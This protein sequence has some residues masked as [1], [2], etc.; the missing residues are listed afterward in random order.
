LENR[1]SFVQKLLYAQGSL[2]QNVANLVVVTWVIYFYTG[3]GG[4]TALIPIALVGLIMGVGRVIDVITDPLVGYWSDKSTYKGGRRRPFI[5]W[6]GPLLALTFYLLWLPPVSE[7]SWWNVLWAFLFINAFFLMLTITIVPFRSVL[8]DIAPNSRERISVSAWQAVFG[9]IGVMI[10]AIS[11]GPIIEAYGY[12]TMGILLA[13]VIL[14]SVWLSLLGIKEKPRSETDLKTTLSLKEALTQTLRNRH[15]LAFAASIISFQV[16][17]QIFMIV[18][19]FFVEVILGES[20]AQVALYQGAFIII[21]MA[22][23]PLWIWLGNRI[24]KRRGQLLSLFL[25]ALLF[26]FYYFVGQIPIL[27][28]S[29]QALIYF[30]LLAVP[31]SGLYVFP[32]ALVGDIADYDELK[33]KKRREAMYYAG[34][35]FMEKAAWALSAFIISIVLP[36]FGFTVENPHGIRLIGPIVGIISVLGLIG[37]LSYRLPD[38]IQGKSLEQVEKG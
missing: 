24:G 36:V 30:G 23:L 7:V 8:P 12:S 38:S 29:I 22:A 31:I 5:L 2:G 34:F 18:L 37:F 3:G 32:N 6:G 19:P 1:I 26:P 28:P 33:T 9:T 27:T 21:M 15:F 14:I 17:F 11:S 20:E 10:A 25:I 16:G 4:R 13:I 35:G